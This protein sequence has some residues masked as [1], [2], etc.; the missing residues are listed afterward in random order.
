MR[1]DALMKQDRQFRV[2]MLSVHSCP[3]GRPGTRDTGGMSIYVQNVA[4]ELGAREIA[5]DIFTRSHQ[6]SSPPIMEIGQNVRLIHIPSGY[7]K[8]KLELFSYLP[9]FTKAIYAF[10]EQEA[11]EYNIIH[12]H[13]W[14]SGWVGAELASQWRIP[15]VIML[16]TSARAKNHH[17]GYSVEP[18]IR[19]ETEQQVLGAANLV[20]AATQ[21]EKQDLADFYGVDPLKIAV[22]P[23]GVDLDTFRPLLK[24]FA[25]RALNLDGLPVVLYVGRLGPEKGVE[26]LLEAVAIVAREWPIQVVIVGGE[27]VDKGEMEHLQS[28]SRKLGIADMIRFHSSVEQDEL[29]LYYSSA[30]VLVLPSQ[31]ETF[32]LVAAEAL[33]CGLPV[34]ASPVGAIPQL[35]QEGKTGFI[36]NSSEPADLANILA[37]FIN[38]EDLRQ[39]LAASARTAVTNLSWANVA[40][41]LAQEYGRLA[42]VA[43]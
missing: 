3:Q 43:I 12:S 19:A 4:R 41:R 8:E 2:A 18:E 38:D 5:V 1:R 32:G 23:C 35:V 30:D 37:R 34:I 21:S 22:I 13:Y 10:K 26:Q 29:P 6:Q 9:D 15:H 16:H 36:L 24:P 40:E 17:L 27:D 28:L 11:I 33:A 20:V 25:R 39:R 14:L 31:Y 42:T 7:N